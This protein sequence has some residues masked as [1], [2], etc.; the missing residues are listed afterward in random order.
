MKRG[1]RTT[2][3]I[4]ASG[5]V[6]AACGSSPSATSATTTTSAAGGQ[7][8]TVLK[9]A[10]TF[11]PSAI[12]PAQGIDAIFSFEETLTQITASGKAV[13]FLLS[14]PPTQT[15]AD[16][17]TL[18]LRPNVT[19]EDGHHMTAAIVAAG[20]NREERLSDTTKTILPGAVFTATGP[21][22]LTVTTPNTVLLM[23]YLLADPSL[24]VYDEPVVAAAGTGPDA[25]VG[26]GVFTAPYAITK[27]TSTEMD[28]VRYNNYWQGRPALAGIDVTQV[29]DPTARAQSVLSGQ[30][31]IADGSNS[32][33][34]RNLIK[35][36]SNV[37]LTLSAAPQ[38][39]YPLYFN[40][41]T[42]PLND[43]NVRRAVALALD[44]QTLAP[45]FTG[46]VDSAAT[47]LLPPGFPL[48]TPIQH[49][50]VA[51][52][53]QL[54]QA[55][56]WT[57]TGIRT[58]GGVPLELTLLI[59]NSRPLLQPLSIG[60]Q[61]ELAK[62]GIGVKINDIPYSSTMYNNAS[63]WNLALYHNYAVSPTGVLDPYLATEV[64]T[65]G[66]ANNWHI[67][68][69]HLDSLLS[70]LSKVSN[71][72]ARATALNNALKYIWNQAYVVNVAFERDGSLVGKQWQ[73]YTP[74]NGGQEGDWNWKTAPTQ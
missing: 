41:S 7:S 28:L 60:I 47:G 24:A 22:Q 34:V 49:Q 17:W 30:E 15:S 54:L 9:L 25:L 31:D 4:V 46:G 45:Q 11:L 21:L 59:Y 14:A 62:V 27:F 37:K 57:G 52:A 67:S 38:G 44:Y 72:A 65:G 53:K 13:P 26:K 19:F 8:S 63:T 69:P 39:S 35:G 55:A 3:V 18:D 74:D 73:G 43:V 2:V 23:P 33:Q 51:E 64:G 1:R 56:G 68:D 61:S 6:V 48:A 36:N 50:N 58:K 70:T 10:A 5:M 20:M 40:P 42:A 16:T 32:P 29:S 66:S 71:Q 12:D